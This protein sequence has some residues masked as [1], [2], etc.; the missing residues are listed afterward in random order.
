MK[1]TILLTLITLFTFG[2]LQA[3]FDLGILD[4]AMSMVKSGDNNTKVAGILGDAVMGLKDEAKQSSGDFSSKLLGQAGILGGLIPAISKGNADKNLLQKVIST[5]KTLVAAQRL[6][7]LLGGGSLLG[8]SSQVNSN[9]GLIQSGLGALGSGSSVDK[10][11]SVL[12]AVT[13]K[14]SKLENTGIFA[15]LAEKAV[16][17]KLGTSLNLLNGLL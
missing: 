2:N 1:K 6:K 16:S 3:Q 10:L 5:I 8:K 13:K 4:N 12:G 7:S 15:N 9:V 14:S 11:S 17:K